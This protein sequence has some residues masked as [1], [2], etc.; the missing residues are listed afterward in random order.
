M[1]ISQVEPFWYDESD[2]VNPEYIQKWLDMS[3]ET[4]I[5]EKGAI[6]ASDIYTNKFS[7]NPKY[8]GK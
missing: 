4:G 3:E 6:K 2:Y 8:A 7:P 1:K 5:L